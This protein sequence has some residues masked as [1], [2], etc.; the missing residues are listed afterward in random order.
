MASACLFS[1]GHRSRKYEKISHLHFYWFSHLKLLVLSCKISQVKNQA[2]SEPLRSAPIKDRRTQNID[3]ASLGSQPQNYREQHKMD[4][5]NKFQ[6]LKADSLSLVDPAESD[7][8]AEKQLYG[9]AD[10]SGA[11]LDLLSRIIQLE[12]PSKR[13][14]RTTQRWE[15]G[16][17]LEGKS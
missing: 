6:S 16:V 12:L 1:V 11:G 14:W 4:K 8:A 3:E 15:H 7:S 13:I 9:S 5:P 17:E 10:I 2:E